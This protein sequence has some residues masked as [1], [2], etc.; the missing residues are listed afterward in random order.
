MA[1]VTLMPGIERISGTVGN[2]IFKTYKN[3]QVRAYSSELWAKC[4]KGGL[5]RERTENG[6]QTDRERTEK[7]IQKES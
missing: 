4:K 1:R 5:T 3:G 2:F 6:P 7:S